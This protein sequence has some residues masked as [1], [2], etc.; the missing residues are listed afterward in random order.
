MTRINITVKGIS[1]CNHS[2]LIF[3]EF[4][5]SAAKDPW[6]I[7]IVMILEVKKSLRTKK[8]FAQVLSMIRAIDIVNL[9]N[10]YNLTE[11]YSVI[12]TLTIWTFIKVTTTNGYKIYETDELCWEGLQKGKIDTRILRYLL[13]WFTLASEQTESIEKG[14]SIIVTS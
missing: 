7:P 2:L 13:H 12:T 6:M 9:Q 5:I 8:S 3:S 10:G 4:P 1:F 11:Y 14:S